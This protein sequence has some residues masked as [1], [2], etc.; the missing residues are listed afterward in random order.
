LR[1]A[2]SWPLSFRAIAPDLSLPDVR[3]KVGATNVSDEEL[4]LRV[5]AGDPAVDAMLAAG[6]PKDYSV[7]SQ[8]LALLISELSKRKQ[9]RQ[10]YIQK[11]GLT[12]RLE[13]GSKADTRSDR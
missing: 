8:P 5:I 1:A 3:R 13:Q 9:Y 6:A 10:V 12:L 4:V 11:N 2:A 7:V